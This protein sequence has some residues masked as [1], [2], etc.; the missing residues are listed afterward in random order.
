MKR[1]GGSKGPGGIRIP[2]FP[3][4]ATIAIGMAIVFFVWNSIV[5]DPE[6][7]KK[8]AA[9]GFRGKKFQELGTKA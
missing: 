8:G 6:E 2:S 1:R 5:F 9:A 3:M 4:V 7:A